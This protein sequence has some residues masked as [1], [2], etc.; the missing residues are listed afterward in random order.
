MSAAV[1]CEGAPPDHDDLLEQ[2][3]RMCVWV[4]HEDLLQLRETIHKLFRALRP[5]SSTTGACDLAKASIAHCIAKP[6]AA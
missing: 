5:A 2:C 6:I 1:N 4:L 3:Q